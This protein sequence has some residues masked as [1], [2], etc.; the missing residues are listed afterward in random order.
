MVQNF[1]QTAA[2]TVRQHCDLQYVSC[3]QDAAAPE[4]THWKY[5][6]VTQKLLLQKLL[7]DLVSCTPIKESASISIKHDEEW[8]EKAVKR[9]LPYTTKDVLTQY[10]AGE[11]AEQ[12][13]HLQTRKH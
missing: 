1:E 3:D 10:S 11:A 12:L 2:L 5:F 4:Y 6:T 9:W 8:K 13:M 7:Q